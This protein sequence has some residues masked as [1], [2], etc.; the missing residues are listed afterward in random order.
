MKGLKHQVAEQDIG[1]NYTLSLLID[2]NN[3][4]ATEGWTEY[5][6]IFDNFW[7]EVPHIC[8]GSRDKGWLLKVYC[9]QLQ[10]PQIAFHLVRKS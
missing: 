8:Q 10:H 3:F 2:I 7:K 5:L 1:P 4:V 9:H 6:T